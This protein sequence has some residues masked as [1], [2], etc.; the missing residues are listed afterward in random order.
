MKLFF[1]CTT[2][3]C[4]AFFACTK[5]QNQPT[6]KTDYIPI[7]SSRSSFTVPQGQPIISTVKMGFYDHFADITFLNFEVKESQPKQYDIRAKA[8]YD[9]IA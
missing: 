3:S 6:S 7:I 4:F 8:F 1:L 9:N 5:P 2:I